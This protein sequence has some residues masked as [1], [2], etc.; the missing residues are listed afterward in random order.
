MKTKSSLPYAHAGSMQARTSRSVRP[1][2]AA[3]P[4]TGAKFEPCQLLLKDHGGGA[5]VC[6]EETREKMGLPGASSSEHAEL[7]GV[8]QPEFDLVG[9]RRLLKTRTP[10]QLRLLVQLRLRRPME[11][12]PVVQVGLRRLVEV[13]LRNP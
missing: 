6:V 5:G 11:L 10:L 12:K 4:H 13:A 7:H 9:R 8:Q 1:L 2:L 3:W